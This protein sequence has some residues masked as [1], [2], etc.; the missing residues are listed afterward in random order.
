MNKR[1][2]AVGI[3]AAL[4]LLVALLSIRFGAPWLYIHDD[5]GVWTQMMASAHL[6]VGLATTGAQGAMVRRTDGGIDRYLHHPPLYPLIVAAV[7]RVTGRSDPAITRFVPAFFHAG[8]GFAA[9]VA[10]AFMFFPASPARRLISFGIYAVVP[11]SAF[12]GK[13]PNFEPVGLAWVLVALVAT[14][15][16]RERGGHKALATATAFWALAGFTSWAAHAVAIGVITLF[17]IEAWREHRPGSG[18]AA[19]SIAA[20]SAFSAVTTIA[21]IRVLEGHNSSVFVA[22]GTWSTT[23]MSPAEALRALGTVI[24]FNRMYFANVPFALYLVWAA[25]RIRDLLAGRPLPEHRRVLLAGSIGITLYALAFLRALTIHAYGQFWFLPFEAFAVAD[26]AVEAW[27]RLRPRP[28][29]RV[30][31]ATLA[32]TGTLVS[33]GYTLA[34]RYSRPHG[35]AVRTAR[36]LAERY[37]TA[38]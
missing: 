5:N 16:Y 32:I 7:Y 17:A 24:D 28:A 22:G 15:R 19:L 8:V 31:L 36:D 29:L 30:A 21:Q 23:G 11:M 18:R 25:A 14:C 27:E 34:Y 38:P 1:T 20:A 6:R 33:S 13:M 35:Y 26:L 2:E 10:L 9:L 3:F 12:F 4:L 37:Y